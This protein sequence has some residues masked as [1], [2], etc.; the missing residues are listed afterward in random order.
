M[1]RGGGGASE[2]ATMELTAL[3]GNAQIKAQLAHREGDLAHAY[4]VAG[5]A[6]SGRHTLAAQMAA[7]LVCSAQPQLRPCGRCSHCRKAAG[8]IHPD[9]TVIAGSGGKPITVDQVRALR[10]DAYVRP[11]EAERKVYL[12]ERAD[13]MNASAQNAMLKLLEDGPAYAVFFLLAENGSA[14]LPT[15]RSRCIEIRIRPI[16]KKELERQLEQSMGKE[17]A[18]FAAAWSGGSYAQAQ[19]IAGDQELAEVRQSAAKV[20]IRL[21]IKKNPSVFEMEK[22]IM[23]QE[24]RMGEVFYAIATLMRDAIYY[25]AGSLQL[26]N[27]DDLDTVRILAE[28]FTKAQ[29]YGIMT[30]AL[31]RGERKRRY[32]QV[33]SKLIIMGLLFDILEVKAKS[34]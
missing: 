20:C 3:A 23:R 1:K 30:L 5:P 14:L 13:R 33:R 21:A 34:V 2:E 27:P 11:N 17:Q 10:T 29:L 12:L 31:E 4:I 24:A 15:V 8:G 22:E 7:A 18:A 9:I 28:R 32:P 19:K 6:G 16:P 25:Q 26:M